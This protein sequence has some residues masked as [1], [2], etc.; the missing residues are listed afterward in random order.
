MFVHQHGEFVRDQLYA[1]HPL[2]LMFWFLKK[3]PQSDVYIFLMGGLNVMSY[4][5]INKEWLVYG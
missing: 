3:T 1:S 4:T 5:K 2:V